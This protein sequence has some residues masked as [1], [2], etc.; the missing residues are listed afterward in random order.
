MGRGD[1]NDGQVVT[2]G[3]AFNPTGVSSHDERK[4]RTGDEI[5][6]SAVKGIHLG[7]VSVRGGD[8]LTS[9]E[10]ATSLTGSTART[11][12][13]WSALGIGRG[14]GGPRGV[15]VIEVLPS[16]DFVAKGVGTKEFSSPLISKRGGTEIQTFSC[17]FSLMMG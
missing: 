17:S 3:S 7:P 9:S 13:T 10:S 12:G 4:S 11:G 5:G 1:T 2:E 6:V 8:D 14:V 16:T 15:M